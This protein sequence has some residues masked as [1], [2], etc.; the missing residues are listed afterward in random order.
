MR[1]RKV[2]LT[3]AAA[4]LAVPCSVDSLG[5]LSPQ[6]PVAQPSVPQPLLQQGWAQEDPGLA[7][8]LALA[9]VLLPPALMALLLL[10]R[11][12]RHRDRGESIDCAQGE[13]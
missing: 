1:A 4:G 8:W 2:L 10:A 13:R 5:V 7:A 11:M 6:A 12:R 3:I 9:L